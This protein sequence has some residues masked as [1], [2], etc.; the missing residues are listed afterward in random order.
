[1]PGSPPKLPAGRDQDMARTNLQRQI[2][3]T[4][5]RGRL[6]AAQIEVEKQAALQRK[7]DMV[8]LADGFERAAGE[9]KTVGAASTE[10][11]A[12]S[13]TLAKCFPRPRCWRATATGWVAQTPAARRPGKQLIYCGSKRDIAIANRKPVATIAATAPAVILAISR[14][15]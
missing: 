9:I 13:S 8:N 6:T 1:M 7:R 12:S 2:F 10:L 5:D 15:V 3:K 11:E 14:L 4:T